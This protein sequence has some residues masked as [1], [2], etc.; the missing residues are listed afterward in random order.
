MSFPIQV[1]FH[2]LDHS[3]A[4]EQKV[5]SAV[6]GLTKFTEHIQKCRVAI[7]MPHRHHQHG[8]SYTVTIQ[9]G[10]P[11]KTIVVS[12]ESKAGDAYVSVEQALHGAVESCARALE[13][14]ARIRRREVKVHNTKQKREEPE[15]IGI[16]D[17]DVLIEMVED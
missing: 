11:G 7:E 15:E 4:L 1:A 10:V 14:W 13:D 6:D 2:G 16:P 3:T 9:V 12:E 17:A 8:N 5:R